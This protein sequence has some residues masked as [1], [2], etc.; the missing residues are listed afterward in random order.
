MEYALKMN[1]S[2]P[3]VFTDIEEK[4]WSLEI[5]KNSLESKVTLSLD[6]FWNDKST[7]EFVV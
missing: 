5:A 2:M 3:T 7:T 6:S 4:L 1:P